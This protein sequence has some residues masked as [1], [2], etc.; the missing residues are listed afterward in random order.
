MEGIV[1]F[2]ASGDD[3]NQDNHHEQTLWCLHDDCLESVEPFH[4]AASL[5]AHT[6]ASHPRSFTDTCNLGRTTFPLRP[7]PSVFDDTLT[8]WDEDGLEALLDEMNRGAED[9]VLHDGPPYANGHLHLGHA[10]NKVMKDAMCKFQRQ[11][12]KHCVLRPGWDCHG[13]PVELAVCKALENDYVQGMS[14]A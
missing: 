8:S 13:L 11:Q 2:E 4:D 6:N 14:R 3:N 10:L 12:G 9:Y 7:A 1:L 5:G